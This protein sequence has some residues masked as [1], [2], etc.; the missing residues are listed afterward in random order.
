MN[1]KKETLFQKTFRKFLRQIIDVIHSNFS[2]VYYFVLIM[3]FVLWIGYFLT[4]NSSFILTTILT[5]LALFLMFFVKD[6]FEEEKDKKKVFKAS[7]KCLY[8]NVLMFI[9][10]IAKLISI[11]IN[12]SKS[13]IMTDS[14][15]SIGITG[16]AGNSSMGGGVG[17]LIV[18]IIELIALIFIIL[19]MRTIE[20]QK[21]IEKYIEF[22]FWEYFGLYSPEEMG[23]GDIFICNDAKD[24]KPVR[25]PYTDRFLHMLIIGPTGC[26]KTSQIITPMLNQDVRNL[27]AGVTVIEPKGD[28]A[29]KIYAMAQFYGRKAI[30]FNPILDACPSF[31]PLYGKEED[32]IENI[33]TTFNMFD[34]DAKQYFKDMNEQLLRNALKILKRFKGNKATLIDLNTLISNPAGEGRMIVNKFM[35]LPAKTE[36]EQKENLDCATYFLESYFN[37]KSKTYENC[38]G[39][40]SQV[41]KITSN[42]FLRK[43]L[44]PTNGKSDLDF[45]KCLAD[46]EVLCITTAQGKLRD[47]GSFLGYF[48]ILNFQSSV[49]KRPGNEDTRRPHFLY[50]DEFQKYSNPGFA[51]MLTQG[52][53]YRVASHLATQA[54]AQIGMGSGKDG[55]AFINLVSTNCRNVVVF[56]GV[57]YDDAKYYSDQFGEYMQKKERVSYS[58]KELN[59][60]YLDKLGAANVSKS[61]EEKLTKNFTPTDII[62]QKK[63]HMLF[64]YV[65][66][67]VV[68]TPLSG[69]I[70]Y[71]PYELNKR[72]NAMIVENEFLMKFGQNPNDCRDLTVEGAPLLP[73]WES[74]M[75]EI[76]RIIIEREEKEYQME[77]VENQPTEAPKSDIEKDLMGINP[78]D[79]VQVSESPTNTNTN[80]NNKNRDF[81]KESKSFSGVELTADDINSLNQN[82]VPTISGLD[83]DDDLI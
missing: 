15:S 38:S 56:P 64:G 19:Y 9:N 81:E 76:K 2:I 78:L 47:L 11:G 40:R 36:A 21:T 1:N 22:D 59:P 42:K 5:L 70:N 35:K 28:L 77:E 18:L 3:D 73:K 32:V 53:S 48:I 79:F 74:Q 27:E 30:Y 43:V 65:K 61:T 4:K 46:G 24:D 31:N 68:Q 20:I 57:S 58:Q 7:E 82:V 80:A 75:E 72:L 45:D 34:P 60:L 12:S 51:D 17:I 67:M 8:L 63:Q 52:R 33:V 49:F 13:K 54:R 39:V 6:S 55:N 69:K 16:L 41:A 37:E 26:G 66:N 44:N 14:I 50:I 23:N 10:H 62:Y 71:I 25:L 83:D 29:E